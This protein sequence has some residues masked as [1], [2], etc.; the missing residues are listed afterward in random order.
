MK[1]ENETEPLE[2]LFIPFLNDEEDEEFR[3]LQYLW[4]ND[5]DNLEQLKTAI[6]NGE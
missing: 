5:K 3:V 6:N 1:K 2:E 4:Q